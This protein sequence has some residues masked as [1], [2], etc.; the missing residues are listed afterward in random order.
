[1]NCL[2]ELRHFPN[3]YTHNRPLC[4]Y[5]HVCEYETREHRHH[6]LLCQS[7]AVYVHL[8]ECVMF[9]T[10]LLH[11]PFLFSKQ[12]KGDFSFW[13]MDADVIRAQT[14]R[15]FSLYV[16]QVRRDVWRD[17]CITQSQS[18]SLSPLLESGSLSLSPPPAL[19]FSL[20]TSHTSQF[21]SVSPIYCVLLWNC[22]SSDGFTVPCI[23]LRCFLFSLFPSHY[24]IVF[25]SHFIFHLNT[26]SLS[27]FL[28]RTPLLLS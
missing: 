21:H 16:C 8:A 4:V 19:S 27:L 24:P 6:A 25:C 7:I 15:K 26:F 18:L 17:V 1:M 10:H 9:Q 13:N 2:S 14:K 28:T 22:L 12:F 5:L 23:F 20:S 3:K 11:P